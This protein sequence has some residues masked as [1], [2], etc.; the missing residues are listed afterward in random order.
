MPSKSILKKKPEELLEIL[1]EYEG[2]VQGLYEYLTEKMPGVKKKSI[3]NKLH[4]SEAKTWRIRDGKQ[5]WTSEE[6]KEAVKLV[7]NYE[8]LKQHMY[9]Y[10]SEHLTDLQQEEIAKLIGFPSKQQY[11]S[12]KQR[13]YTWTHENMLKAL[14]L[15]KEWSKI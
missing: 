12:S 7:Q 2:L 15:A 14:E 8:F 11:R 6:M 4:Q 1:S 3:S 10:T 13:P 5:D 9:S